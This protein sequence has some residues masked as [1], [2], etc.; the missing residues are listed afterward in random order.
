MLTMLLVDGDPLVGYY[1][2]YTEPDKNLRVIIKDGIVHKNI[3]L[4]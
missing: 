1:A 3:L 2:C 4:N